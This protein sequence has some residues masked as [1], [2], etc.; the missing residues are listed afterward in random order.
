[1]GRG[2][3]GFNREQPV[4][5]LSGSRDGVGRGRKRKKARRGWGV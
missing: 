1:M 3:A 4:A 5:P 2:R